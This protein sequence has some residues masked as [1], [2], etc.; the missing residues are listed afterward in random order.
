MQELDNFRPHLLQF[1][2]AFYAELTTLKL[3]ALTQKKKAIKYIGNNTFPTLAQ[4]EDSS[5][6]EISDRLFFLLENQFTQAQRFESTFGESLYREVQYIMAVFADEVFL[7][8]PSWPGKP[9]WESHL[10]EERIFHTHVAG[11]KLFDNLD[12]FLRLNDPTRK[13]TAMLYLSVLGLGFRG[14][15]R[16]CNDKGQLRAYKEKLF[17]FIHQKKTSLQ[18]ST[19]HL[20][21]SA[22]RSTI[23]QKAQSDVLQK[24][25][26]IWSLA[27]A[28]V[29]ALYLVFA[30][31][32]WYSST[33]EISRALVMIL[34]EADIE[35]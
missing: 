13:E 23:S 7:S 8:L 12:T 30:Y 9:Y 5:T 35:K 32:I 21:P 10:L 11:S 20:F 1:F 18:K 19:A 16:G 27:F 22:L 3:L 4:T 33:H 31:I 2:Y 25:K 6:Q 34:D 17:F 28:A 29:I 26:R 14:K 24:N 15:Y